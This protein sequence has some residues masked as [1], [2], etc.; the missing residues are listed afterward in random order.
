M[1]YDKLIEQLKNAA[2]GPEGIKMCQDAA[3]ALTLLQTEN[4]KLWAMLEQVKAEKARAIET[5]SENLRIAYQSR[6]AAVED[7]RKLAHKYCVCYA[8]END[9]FDYDK[10]RCTGCQYN[11]GHNWQWRGPKE[12]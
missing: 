11:N 3:T 4:E 2:G 1:D 8:C 10:D 7:L 9:K 12:V 5:L 6:D